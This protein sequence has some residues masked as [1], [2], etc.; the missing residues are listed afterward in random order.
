MWEE[1]KNNYRLIMKPLSYNPERFERKNLG[2]KHY[3][4]F[5]GETR[6]ETMLKLSSTKSKKFK[7]KDQLKKNVYSH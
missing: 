2:N 4:K 7:T 3:Q 1:E 6:E 5:L